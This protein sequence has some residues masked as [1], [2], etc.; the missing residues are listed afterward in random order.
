MVEKQ[1]KLPQIKLSE[2]SRNTDKLTVQHNTGS[3][4]LGCSNVELDS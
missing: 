1:P 3:K 4:E 2:F